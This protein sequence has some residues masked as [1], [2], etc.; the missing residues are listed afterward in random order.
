MTGDADATTEADTETDGDA[1]VEADE[2][3]VCPVCGSAFASAS[4]HDE[5]L[6]VELGDDSR[7]DRVCVQP[8][9]TEDGTPLVR[10]FQH[11]G[12]DE[13]GTPGGRIP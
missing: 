4:L 2:P 5:G 13:P 10:L 6:L 12:R 3:V 7:F 1:G 8:V 9:S 11:P